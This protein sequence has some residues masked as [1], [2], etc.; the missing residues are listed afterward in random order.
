[1]SGVETGLADIPSSV[2]MPAGD[3][4]LR[5]MLARTAKASRDQWMTLVVDLI[6]GIASKKKEITSDD[7][8][9][10][11]EGNDDVTPVF[12]GRLLGAAFLKASF[13][14]YVDTSDCVRPSTR[15]ACHRRPIRIWESCIVGSKPHLSPL[16]EK[17]FM[18]KSAEFNAS[19]KKAKKPR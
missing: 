9:F 12:D 19:V 6:A 16:A 5:A 3:E 1:M 11:I 18:S 13:K 8:W 7:V 2:D 17:L 4:P 10:F 14:G 15:A